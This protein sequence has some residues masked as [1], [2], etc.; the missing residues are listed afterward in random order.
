MISDWCNRISSSTRINEL[1]I[2]GTHDAAAWT[3]HWK[4]PGIKGTWAQRKSITEQL[5]LGVRV[6]D[7]RVGY[8]SSYWTIG[9]TSFIGM[10]H[11]PIYLSLTL[12]K[13][14]KDV[15]NWLGQHSNEFV[16]LIFQQ[17]GKPMQRDVSDGVRT[18]VRDTFGT[19]LHNFK[20]NALTWPTVGDLR[21]KVLAMGRLQSDVADF[22]NVRSWL[23]T[24]DNTDS[25][26]INAGT[27][28]HIF[29][30]DRYKGLSSEEGYKS[31]DQDNSKKFAKVKDAAKAKPNGPPWKLL[32]INHMSYSNLRYQP[33]QSGEG[34]NKL[35]R[36][37][38]IKIQG[39]L[40]IDDADQATVKHILQNNVSFREN[41]MRSLKPGRTGMGSWEV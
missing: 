23:S 6:L 32:R 10:F 15:N 27:N 14:L 1:A 18:L 35:L 22:C 16:I 2:P 20:P 36:D 40:M 13:V 12:E 26:V 9:I 31:M 24:G 28:L 17:Q 21:G 38:K 7:L 11:G 29:L 5:D 3:H 33:W 41:V 25:V 39:V 37:S 19:K 8:A 34:V 30:Q 4:A